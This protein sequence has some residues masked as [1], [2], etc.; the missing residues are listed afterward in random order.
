MGGGGGGGGDLLNS[1]NTCQSLDHIYIYIT[2]IILII[3]FVFIGYRN[4]F[5]S[6]L[7][8]V[9]DQPTLKEDE[10]ARRERDGKE[11]KATRVTKT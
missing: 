1:P 2:N 8:I 5:I 11:N 9:N 3:F 4:V 6:F 10:A 7:L